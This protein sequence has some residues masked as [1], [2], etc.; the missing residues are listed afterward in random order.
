M[1]LPVMAQG[2]GATSR[3]AVR[4]CVADDFVG[5]EYV[6]GGVARDRLRLVGAHVERT[7]EQ[8]II[9]RGVLGEAAANQWDS[10]DR[11]CGSMPANGYFLFA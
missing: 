4:G 2:F 1:A 5:G 3:R 8:A 9:A 10:C 11:G 7:L 6:E